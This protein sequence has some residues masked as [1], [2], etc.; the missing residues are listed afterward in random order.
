MV[1]SDYIVLASGRI[2]CRRC[3]AIIKSTGQQCRSP[4]MAKDRFCWLHAKPNAYE[5]RNRYGRKSHGNSTRDARAELSLELQQL[6]VIE[7]IA[8]RAGLID[9][10]SRGR[11]PGWRKST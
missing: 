4:S 3:Q 9:E 5:W 1:E 7:A 6:A 11:K 10:P 8:L 2:V